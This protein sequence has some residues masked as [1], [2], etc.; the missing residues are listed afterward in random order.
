[1]YAFGE[2]VQ[3]SRGGQPLRTLYGGV[4]WAEH[5]LFLEP[6]SDVRQGDLA[7]FRGL[8]RRINANPQVWYNPMT[9]WD[10]G[11]VAYF[12][13]DPAF[14]PDWGHIR[15]PSP[16]PTLNEETGELAYTP[17]PQVWSG[18]CLV[19]PGIGQGINPND[20]AGQRTS[21]MTHVITVPLDCTDVMPEDLFFVT[22]SRDPLLTTRTL[23]VIG[24]RLTSTDETR[25]LL[26]RDN[27]G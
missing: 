21:A 8:T 22:T 23:V 26:V 2:P 25:D 19:V 16:Q 18:P 12:D 6:G 10:A 1:M 14:L 4:D 20:F 13:P 9:G 11:T 3:V 15:R 24:V 27:Q 5:R 17:G 7:S